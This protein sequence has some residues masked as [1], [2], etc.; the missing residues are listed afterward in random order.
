MIKV[1][2]K[3]MI[4]IYIKEECHLIIIS[5]IVKI[6]LRVKDITK[7]RLKEHIPADLQVC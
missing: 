1:E 2:I 5:L 4:Y 3:K 7:A 6:F